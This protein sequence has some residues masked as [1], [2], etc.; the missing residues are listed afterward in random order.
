[1]HKRQIHPQAPRPRPRPRPPKGGLLHRCY[2]GV[3]H[4]G[5]HAATQELFTTAHTQLRTITLHTF[6]FNRPSTTVTH[7]QEGDRLITPGG[8]RGVPTPSLTSRSRHTFTGPT[9]TPPTQCLA[10]S[11]ERERRGTVQVYARKRA[12]VSTL[13][14][15]PTRGLC[16]SASSRSPTTAFSTT[17]SYSSFEDNREWRALMFAHSQA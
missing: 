7:K 13:K 2:A 16:L 12:S 14:L 17:E 3:I 1:M 9:R 6:I 11:S 8:S 5:T 4:N 15:E 10:P